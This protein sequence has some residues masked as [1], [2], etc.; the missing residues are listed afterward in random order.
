MVVVD[1]QALVSFGLIFC[2]NYPVMEIRL[3]RK[4]DFFIKC[5]EWNYPHPMT[6]FCRKV[7]KVFH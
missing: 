3:L 5:F 2:G 6:A 7:V 1:F 4:Q